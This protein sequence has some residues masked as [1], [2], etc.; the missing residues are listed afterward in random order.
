MKRVL[1]D[2]PVLTRRLFHHEFVNEINELLEKTEKV[3]KNPNFKENPISEEA[4]I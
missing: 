1:K 4:L 3:F 2:K